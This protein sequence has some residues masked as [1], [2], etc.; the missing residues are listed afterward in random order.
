MVA[1]KN[2]VIELSS[3]KLQTIQV[4]ILGK[5]LL[6]HAWS[7]KAI[8]EMLDKQM[9]KKPKVREKKDPHADYMASRYVAAH[10]DSIL[11][12]PCGAFRGAIVRASSMH[13]FKMTEMRQS[14][15]I[16][17]DLRI[18]DGRGG[19]PGV[20]LYGDDEMHET[21]VRLSGKTADIRYRA[22]LPKWGAILTITYLSNLS[23]EE[24]VT[25]VDFAGFSV[26]ICDWRPEKDGE[27]G[28]WNVVN[29]DELVKEFPEVANAG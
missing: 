21:M 20:R 6:M 24:L 9:G 4:P 27:F 15:F 19:M 14:F 11:G 17:E 16:E 28:R 3:I 8:Q 10:D 7:R 18:V 22:L 5:N 25:L 12:V 23:S 29:M 1:K 26:G 13:N 2:D